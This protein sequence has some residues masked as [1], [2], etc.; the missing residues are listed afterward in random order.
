MRDGIIFYRSF[1]E[2]IKDMPDKEFADAARAILDYGLDGIEH[3]EPGYG[4][5][6]FLMAKPQIDK[7]NERYENGKKGGRTKAE[8]NG[9]QTIT[10]SEPND[11]QTITKAE[12][13]VKDKVKEKDKVKDKVK[14]KKSSVRQSR[15]I[16]PTRQE[17]TAY[18]EEQKITIDADRFLDFYESKG[19]MVGKNKMKDWKAT[20][21][22][23][24]RGQ[25]QE[26]T[27]KG[28]KFSNF[29][30]RS[31]DFESMER[32]LLEN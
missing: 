28:T 17:L 12:P 18:C 31:Y 21:R 4:R 30:E 24:N 7:N 25:R 23:W 22:N 5:S 27:A 11:N 6:I 14:D 1:Y 29:P 8:P 10:E 16:P 20:V 19:W 2:A 15:F 9:N 32:K 26:S 3:N 13:K